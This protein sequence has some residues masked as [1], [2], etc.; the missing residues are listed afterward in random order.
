M[1]NHPKLGNLANNWIQL[2]KN[3]SERRILQFVRVAPIYWRYVIQYLKICV[4][5]YIRMYTA[6]IRYYV[7]LYVRLC[8]R[9]HVNTCH[10]FLSSPKSFNL[11]PLPPSAFFVVSFL[12]VFPRWGIPSTSTCFSWSPKLANCFWALHWRCL[13][14]ITDCRISFGRNAGIRTVSG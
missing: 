11:H 9:L 1:K 2:E 13:K 3:T 12:Q 8:V 10:N 14:D 5:E 6:Y 4:R 7:R